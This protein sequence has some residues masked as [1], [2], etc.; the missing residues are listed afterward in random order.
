MD[1]QYQNF[2]GQKPEKDWKTWF[3]CWTWQLL[4]SYKKVMQDWNLL[5]ETK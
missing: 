3:A 1:Y 2:H 5:H 4:T